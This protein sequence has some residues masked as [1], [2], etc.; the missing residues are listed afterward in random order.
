[1]CLGLSPPQALLFS[2]AIEQP[3]VRPDLHR[4]TSTH[5]VAS[6]TSF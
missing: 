2:K 1:M 6:V 3:D 5:T 4:P